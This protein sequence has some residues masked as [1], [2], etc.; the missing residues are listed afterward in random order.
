MRLKKTLILTGVATV[1][2]AAALPAAAQQ[3]PLKLGALVPLTG[4]LQS[5]GETSLKGIQL[6][7]EEINKAGGVLGQ[8][9]EV[10]VG[11]DQTSP[12]VAVDAAQKL[13]SV[14]GVSAIAGALASGPTIAVAK[15]VTSANG[16]P[17]I[18]GSS[19]SPEITGLADK[20][21]LFR[22][23]PS[24][25][26]QGVA[27]AE[28]VKA[29]GYKSVAVVFV[30]NDYGQGLNE[31]FKQSFEKMGGKVSQSVAF[32]EKQPS[33]RGELQRAAQGK[34]EAMVLIAY[35]ASG[36]QVVKQ[37]LEGGF[38]QKFAFSDGVKSPEMIKQIGAKYL[39][40]A[41]GTAPQAPSGT[42][43]EAFKKAYEAKYGELPPKP[44]IDN[45]YDATYLF[46]LAAEKAKSTD[47]KAIQAALRDVTNAPGEKV[48][49]GE[50]AKARDL[51][52]AGKDVDYV[53]A[54]GTLEF[55]AAGDVGGSFAEWVIE[56][57][58]IKTKRVFE[59]KL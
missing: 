25:A 52:K 34:P 3:K 18:S 29:K 55:D 33:F 21:M 28:V 30:N 1:A 57:G 39:E 46:A 23:T 35:P 9:M 49:P 11:D 27:L 40:G 6:A 15:S 42:E 16:I 10:V 48:G 13:V 41:V 8:P 37:A 31:A 26:F 47:P 17:Q 51:I 19:T 12:Q 24:D 43:V 54:S 4:S 58:E 7:A 22:T 20:D 56:G 45:F 2:L 59:P 32:E 38:F 50:F 36:T 5:Y 53:G 44:Y 14:N